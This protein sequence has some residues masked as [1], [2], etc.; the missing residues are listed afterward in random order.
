MLH[1]TSATVGVSAV[2][3]RKHAAALQ[4]WFQNLTPA[5]RQEIL[6]V[7]N[8]P[9]IQLLSQMHLKK[10]HEGEGAFSLLE[11][12]SWDSPAIEDKVYFHRS[13]SLVKP[14]EW[15]FEKEI[16]VFDAQSYSD[17]FTVTETLTQGTLRFIE[18]ALSIS[19]DRIF[20]QPCRAL[21]RPDNQW[22]WDLP[23]WF[24][25]S[26]FSLSQLALALLEQNVWKRYWKYTKENPGKTQI[27]GEI[28]MQ[29]GALGASGV[30]NQ[31]VEYWRTLKKTMRT[32]VVGDLK[33]LYAICTETRRM[34]GF[35]ALNNE[36][37]SV[38]SSVSS[39]Q[40]HYQAM[41]KEREK[42]E[43]VEALESLK[44]MAVN[45]ISYKFLSGLFYS[46]L[47]RTGTV[48]DQVCRQ[49][50]IRI[51]TAYTLH[52]A[53]STIRKLKREKDGDGSSSESSLFIQDPV[54]HQEYIFEDE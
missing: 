5:E 48:Y 8:R 4:L 18:L 49:L 39:A 21:L 27:L 35:S 34:G 6:V 28:P 17:S 29:I 13:S 9:L 50:V 52:E 2:E 26:Y 54:F 51:R 11:A 30:R 1:M 31:L 46:P 33:T 36:Y 19:E 40:K 20:S 3:E 53:S 32:K 38:V 14:E 37:S 24:N 45:A 12:A 10:L 23:E 47:H 42:W 16:R 41:L 22:I 25:A 44:D 7:T 15:E 43:E